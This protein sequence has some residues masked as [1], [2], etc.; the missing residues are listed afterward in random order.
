VEDARAPDPI[1]NGYTYLDDAL[2]SLSAKLQNVGDG[3]SESERKTYV[4]ILTDGIQD[5]KGPSGNRVTSTDYL[6]GCTAVKS[7]GV[8][9]VSILAPVLPLTGADTQ[10]YVDYIQPIAPNV[11]STLK[12]CSS[13]PARG[14]FEATSGPAISTAVNTMLLQALA[15][16]ALTR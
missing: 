6:S 7:K 15:P 5:V 13:D 1:H 11:A 2:Y 10:K 12:S 3:S 8:E 16:L 14:F 9:L 4:V